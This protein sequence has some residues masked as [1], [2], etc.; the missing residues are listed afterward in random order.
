MPPYNS[1]RTN[2]RACYNP[3]PLPDDIYA[4][5]E[6]SIINLHTHHDYPQ[7]ILLTY[8]YPRTDH[9]TTGDKPDHDT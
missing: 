9:T 6:N 1:Y 8:D 4:D 5:S 3:D 7:D 2:K